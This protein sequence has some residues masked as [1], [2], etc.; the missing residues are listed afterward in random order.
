M[1]AIVRPPQ[2]VP[3]NVPPIT[4]RP[5][6]TLRTLTSLLHHAADRQKVQQSH[7]VD[8]SCFACCGVGHAESGPMRVNPAG[9]AG[10]LAAAVAEGPLAADQM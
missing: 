7:S 2:T 6:A 8:L 3:Q 10:A 5:R 1:H 9:I 4:P